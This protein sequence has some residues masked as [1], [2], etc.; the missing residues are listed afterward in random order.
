MPSESVFKQRAECWAVMSDG[1]WR[2]TCYA[3]GQSFHNTPLPELRLGRGFE[4]GGW[5][6]G[7]WAPH[8]ENCLSLASMLRCRMHIRV[9]AE[10]ISLVP[11]GRERSKAEDRGR[12]NPEILKG[13]GKDLKTSGR[14]SRRKSQATAVQASHHA[15]VCSPSRSHTRVH[16]Y[17]W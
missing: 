13:E 1:L 6:G 15:R 11:P 4:V 16:R 2:V 3:D 17:V 12:S 14:P 9:R 10:P 5:G 7:L 8:L